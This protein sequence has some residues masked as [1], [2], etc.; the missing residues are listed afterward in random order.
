MIC[1]ACTES[2]CR[3]GV[4]QMQRLVLPRFLNGEY[5]F[6]SG[7][8]NNNPYYHIQL[9]GEPT[10]AWCGERMNHS[11]RKVLLYSDLERIA[12][13]CPRCRTAIREMA[14]ELQEKSNAVP[15]DA[16]ENPTV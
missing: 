2:V 8:V 13:L 7:S 15:S 10:H 11:R 6:R 9:I 5:P 4:I 16:A 14:K 1:A 3:E 12:D